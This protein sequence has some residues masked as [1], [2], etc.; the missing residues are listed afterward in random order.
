[1]AN[2]GF[3]RHPY[4]LFYFATLLILYSTSDLLLLVRP[5]S[6]HT[7]KFLPSTPW[8]LP[9]HEVKI[10]SCAEVNQ[11]DEMLWTFPNYCGEYDNLSFSVEKSCLS[12][13]LSSIISSGLS[14]ESLR[15]VEWIGQT[16]SESW[17]LNACLLGRPYER[18]EVIES[19]I[20][21]PIRTWLLQ[22]L[23]PN[24]SSNERV[25]KLKLR[26]IITPALSSTNESGNYFF[27]V[28]QLAR[29]MTASEQGAQGGRE[30]LSAPGVFRYSLNFLY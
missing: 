18:S 10:F 5:R 2:E 29:G 11:L 22:H 27:L 26:V 28:R 16:V 4:L 8:L 12:H 24:Y 19:Q 30:T 14:V 1:M 9:L 23:G 6:R 13:S 20:L 17:S 25:A 21:L 3:Y 7:A 15:N